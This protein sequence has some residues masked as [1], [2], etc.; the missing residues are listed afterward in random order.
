MAHLDPEQPCKIWGFLAA[1]ETRRNIL[2]AY[3]EGPKTQIIGF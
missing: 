1:L 3:P 2:E